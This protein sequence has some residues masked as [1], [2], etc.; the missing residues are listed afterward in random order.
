MRKSGG[1][2]KGSRLSF[3]QDRPFRPQI[4]GSDRGVQCAQRTHTQTLLHT[5]T[6]TFVPG[7]FASEREYQTH[8]K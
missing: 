6:Q 3:F 1:W 5:H 4:T 2:D 8:S 7:V